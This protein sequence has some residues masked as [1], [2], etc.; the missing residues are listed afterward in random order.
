MIVRKNKRQTVLIAQDLSV[1]FF[2][3]WSCADSDVTKR[4]WRILFFL[5]LNAEIPLKLAHSKTEKTQM[6]LD[7]TG[8]VAPP[9]PGSRPL[10]G[11]R[12]VSHQQTTPSATN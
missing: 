4:Y 5:F 12:S 9:K 6:A 10:T 2:S 3:P 8:K 7:S 11:R 1:H